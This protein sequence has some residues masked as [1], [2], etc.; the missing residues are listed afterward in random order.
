MNLLYKFC[1]C[2]WYL[3]LQ[4]SMVFCRDVR[5][6]DP[7]YSLQSPDWKRTMLPHLTNLFGDT[8]E[9]STGARSQLCTHEL[10]VILLN[11]TCCH[12]FDKIAFPNT[13]EKY[14]DKCFFPWISSTSD[15]RYQQL[16]NM[17]SFNF[18][19]LEFSLC[20][21]LNLRTFH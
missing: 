5:G 14:L 7:K 17:C 10:A 12:F 13:S 19:N 18:Q 1:D 20:K 11:L 8:T 16:S 6:K 3:F 15:L 21:R 2:N 4:R 9:L